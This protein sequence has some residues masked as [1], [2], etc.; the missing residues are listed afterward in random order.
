VRTDQSRPGL[1]FRRERLARYR[2]AEPSIVDTVARPTLVLATSGGPAPHPHFFAGQVKSPRLIAEL[3]TAVHLVVNSRFFTPPN[4]LARMI[5]VIACGSAREA[6]R[7]ISDDDRVFAA[8]ERHKARRA[9]GAAGG[10]RTH[11]LTSP[12]AQLSETRF[13]ATKD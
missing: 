3:L 8:L 6:A 1:F 9:G 4:A 5:A 10:D 2:Y 11:L 13:A 7:A 12:V